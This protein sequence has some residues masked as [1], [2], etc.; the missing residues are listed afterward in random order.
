MNR[1]EVR[2]VFMGSPKFAVYILRGL[3]ENGF[4]IVKVVTAPDRPAGRGQKIQ[5][6]AVK[7]YALTQNLELLQPL[8]L[9]SE[10]FTSKLKALKVDLQ[11][12]VAFRILP[13]I[14]WDIP[15]LGTFNLHASLLP[16]YRGAA[17]IN[18]ALI[19]GE[20]ETGVTSFFIDD[21][22]DTG[23]VIL[24]SKVSISKNET[25][26]SLHNKLMVE[27]QKLVLKT[28]KVIIQGNV[29]TSF[30]SNEENLK[31]APKLDRKNCKI[32]WTKNGK[33]IQN[34]VRGLNPYPCAWTSLQNGDNQTN[35]KIYEVAF[36]KS[37]NSG[38]IGNILADKKT[39]KIAVKKGYIHLIRFK[40]SGKKE[41]DVKSFLNGFIFK[42][43]AKMI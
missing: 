21:K 40:L 12:V 23:A 30:Q 4:N 29:T 22:I 1:K 18:W 32:D 27:G 3:V 7:K 37:P 39:L 5:K 33:Q 16:Q 26:G 24:Q 20:T 34:L 35:I 36:E 28:T 17:P 11:I 15:K 43:K 8:N 2:I 41:M 10:D 9:K 14:V 38:L 6:S 13:K 42:D 31:K 19:N 25:A